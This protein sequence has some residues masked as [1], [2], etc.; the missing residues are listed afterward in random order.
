M[1]TKFNLIFRDFCFDSIAVVVASDKHQQQQQ[2]QQQYLFD[3]FFIQN[4]CAKL[5]FPSSIHCKSGKLLRIP[6]PS[7]LL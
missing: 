1:K 6:T 3:N 2:Q 4:I 7:T 5:N